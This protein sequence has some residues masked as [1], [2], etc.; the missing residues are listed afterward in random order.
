[1]GGMRTICAA[2]ENRRLN[3]SSVPLAQP[4]KSMIRHVFF[5]MLLLEARSRAGPTV[6]NL[7]LILELA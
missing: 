2:G 4:N 7:L 3:R 1:M 5:A 6:H